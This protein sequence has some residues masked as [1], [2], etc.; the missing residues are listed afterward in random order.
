M[1]G[2]SQMQV[3]TKPGKAVRVLILAQVLLALAAIAIASIV[4]WQI[5]PLIKEKQKLELEKKELE[6]KI[7]EKREQIEA[8]DSEIQNRTER[9][10]YIEE[11]TRS[12]LASRGVDRSKVVSLN[13]EKQGFLVILGSYKNLKYASARAKQLRKH[14]SEEVNVYYAINDYFAPAIGV[15][16]SLEMAQEKLKAAQLVQP[17]AYI[18][19]S[20]AFPFQVRIDGI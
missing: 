11:A 3:R 16:D 6:N 18:F 15:L 8:L 13:Q 17:D 12:S 10:N 19:G 5:K 1:E 4:G 14:L 2:A 7:T 9:L 20:W